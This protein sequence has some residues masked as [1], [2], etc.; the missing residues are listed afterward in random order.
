MRSGLTFY[1]FLPT[2][3]PASGCFDN[4]SFIIWTQFL[5]R[6][7]ADL[8][9]GIIWIT[10]I[11]MSGDLHLAPSHNW[12][13]DRVW[14]VLLF[15]MRWKQL[16]TSSILGLTEG[17][18]EAATVWVGR[19]MDGPVE[20]LR[21]AEYIQQHLYNCCCSRVWILLSIYL[22]DSQCRGWSHGSIFKKIMFR[23]F[24]MLYI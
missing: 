7:G 11:E 6:T 20:L 14:K 21:S 4:E 12:W 23:D 19:L 15:E 2:Q 16:I 9:S 17:C 18:S 3:N 13:H 22:Y 24:E 1:V 10:M 8:M 5:A